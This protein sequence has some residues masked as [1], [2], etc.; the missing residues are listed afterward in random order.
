MAG[1]RSAKVNLLKACCEYV[2]HSCPDALAAL[3]PAK[4]WG[5]SNILIEY[6]FSNYCL[7]CYTNQLRRRVGQDFKALSNPLK[8]KY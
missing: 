2:A 1:F 5:A 8:F 4:L 3:R 7:V 6:A